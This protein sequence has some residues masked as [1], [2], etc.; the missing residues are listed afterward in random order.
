[1]LACCGFLAMGPCA[2]DSWS[3]AVNPGVHGRDA[4]IGVELDLGTFD[5]VLPLSLL[6]D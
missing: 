5:V 3:L 4:F 1:M 6:V 2:V